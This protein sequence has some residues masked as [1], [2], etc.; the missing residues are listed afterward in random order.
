MLTIRTKFLLSISVAAVFFVILGLAIFWTQEKLADSVKAVNSVTAKMVMMNDLQLAI[1]ESL[2]PANDYIITGDTAY[3]KEFAEINIRVEKL[4]SDI[5]A[6]PVFTKEEKRD[7]T[8]TENLY[9]KVKAASAAIFSKSHKSEGLPELMKKLDYEYGGPAVRKISSLRSSAHKAL[10]AGSEKAIAM[11]N[12]TRSMLVVVFAVVMVVGLFFGIFI[13]QSITR[14]INEVVR[15]FNSIAE[16]KGDLTS[17]LK[18]H[19]QDELGLLSRWFNKF[20]EG[21]QNMIREMIIAFSEFSRVAYALRSSSNGLQISTQTQHRALEEISSSIEEMDTSVKA[22]ASDVADLLESTES[23]SASSLEVSTNVSEVAENT[24]RLTTSVDK[25]SSAITQIAVSLKE[26]AGSVDALSVDTES[27][28][29]AV[30]EINSAIMEIGMRSQEQAYLSEKVKSDAVTLGI[31]AIN[32][33]KEGMGKIKNEVSNAA[34]VINGLGER[35]SEIGKIVDV[36]NGIAETTNLLALNAAILAAQAGEYG[37]GF[38]VVADQVKNLAQRTADSTK[39]IGGLITQVQDEVLTAVNSMER[40]TTRV[41]D[42]V[43]L[44]EDAEDALNKIIESAEASLEM[45]VNMERATDEQTK[46]IVHI[47]DTIRKVND[48]VEGIKKATDEQKGASQEILYATEDISD[49]TR[50]VKQATG[51]QSKEIKHITDVITEVAHNMQSVARATTEQRKASEMILKAI[52][53]IKNKTNENISLTEDLDR[54]AATLDRHASVLS[55]KV[56]S[57]KV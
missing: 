24:E 31:E 11:K 37:K 36:I 13:A 46:S 50:R 4:F 8:D 43:K 3:K 39:E 23:A 20:V 7:I 33:T 14:P 42:G 28:V 5:K 16:G 25:V 27:V 53:T 38:A 56:G 26:V 44:S 41:Q 9:E 49:I 35:S 45:A 30:T 6:S 57:F 12:F 52:E 47:A 54:T 15:M 2:M 34:A 10:E 18:V 1:N 21:M 40:T 51:E 48:M 32:N 22:V 29:S 19:S 55:Q 17:R